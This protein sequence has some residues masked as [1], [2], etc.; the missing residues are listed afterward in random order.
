MAR[1]LVRRLIRKICS[2]VTIL[3]CITYLVSCLLPYL[4]PASWWFIGFLGLTFPYQATF[5]IFA[6]IFWLI[7]KPRWALFPLITLLVGYKQLSVLFAVHPSKDFT[8]AKTD[9][10]IRIVDWNVGNMYG[11][12]TN[13]EIRKHNRT[14]IAGAILKLNPDIICLQEFNHST[15]QGE[16]AN[17]IGL[18]SGKYQH[19][20][21]PKDVDKE[22][23][24]YQ[25]GSIIF[26]KYPIINAARIPFPHGSVESIIYADILLNGDT[27]RLFTSHLQSFKFNNS[28]Y[29]DINRIKEQNKESLAAS[30][31][32]IT[33]MRYAFQRRGEQTDVV[34][35]VISQCPYSSIMCGDFNDVPNSYTYFQIR[36]LRQ[37][38][39]LAKGFGIGKSYNA[40]APTLRI[41]YI[42]PDT[43]FNIHQFDMVDE[44]LSDHSM[45]VS[46]ISLKKKNK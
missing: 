23:G 7:A 18:F 11:L 25:Y 44:D 31:N 24:Y 15:K 16:D 26:S 38:A 20:Y 19:Y 34:H 17:N 40:I 1:R 6:I 4:N 12:S 3:C 2:F 43:T 21:F 8:E 13:N 29:E 35:N 27:V 46:D 28:D 22:N 14:E 37:D 32:I 36:G 33:K 10:T 5:L 39:F 42:L 30:K 9:T 45:L 41:D